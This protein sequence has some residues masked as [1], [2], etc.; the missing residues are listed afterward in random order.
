VE[1]RSRVRAR[2]RGRH[3][4]CADEQRSEHCD[5]D[6]PANDPQRQQPAAARQ[7]RKVD[8]FPAFAAERA[9]HRIR[10]RFA[11]RQAEGEIGAERV[12]RRR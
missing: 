12:E 7:R 1:Q 6:L 5:R 4:G 2:I 9:E 10:M 8:P 11:H 3:D